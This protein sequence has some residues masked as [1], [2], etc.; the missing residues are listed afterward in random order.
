[1]FSRRILLAATMLAPMLLGGARV[2]HAEG[3]VY[4]EAVPLQ[5][6]PVQ[7]DQAAQTLGEPHRQAHHRRARGAGRRRR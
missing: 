1:M 3:G 7:V 4:P 2:G 6:T 5:P